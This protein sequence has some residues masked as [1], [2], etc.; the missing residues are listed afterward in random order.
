MSVRV[1]VEL[2]Y[3]VNMENFENYTIRYGVSDDARKGESVRDA[4]KRVEKLV[5]ELL[6]AEVEE[7]RK[8][9]ADNLK[10]ARPRGR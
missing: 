1:S 8:V 7:A 6:W 2:E 10:K 4:H 9:A 3:K 5:S